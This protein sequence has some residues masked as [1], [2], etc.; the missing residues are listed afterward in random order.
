VRLFIHG[1]SDV[2]SNTEVLAALRLVDA[3]HGR[4]ASAGANGQ[5]FCPLSGANL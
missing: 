2:E 3:D 5:W 1:E 4:I